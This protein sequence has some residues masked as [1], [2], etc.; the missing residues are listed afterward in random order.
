MRQGAAGASCQGYESCLAPLICDPK[1]NTCGNPLADGADCA[2][3]DGGAAS[4]PVCGTG[5]ACQAAFDGGAPT[6]RGVARRGEPCGLCQGD[7]RCVVT[8]GSAVGTCGALGNTGDDCA[9]DQDC[10]PSLFCKPSGPS[11]FGPGTCAAPGG[12]GAECVSVTSCQ[13]GLICSSQ[14]PSDGGFFP[15]NRCSVSDAGSMGCVP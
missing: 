15:E 12:V 8:A 14:P 2:L 4:Y 10:V 3:L 6:C 9:R 11:P 5:I 13:S 7:L 1:T